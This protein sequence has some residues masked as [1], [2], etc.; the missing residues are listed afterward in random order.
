MRFPSINLKIC[1]GDDTLCAAAAAAASADALEECE[2]CE[3]DKEALEERAGAEAE[4]R[5]DDKLDFEDDEERVECDAD[6]SG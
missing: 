3:E 5:R 6:L 1:F 4:P 2:E